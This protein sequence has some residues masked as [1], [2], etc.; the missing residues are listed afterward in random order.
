MLCPRCGHENPDGARFCG[1]C[2]ARLT[3]AGAVPLGEERKIVSVLFCDLVGF[4]E[5]SELF[6][7][8]GDR[9]GLAEVDELDRRVVRN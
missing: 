1:Q 5:A 4:T 6:A 7:A 9:V 3:V 8:M 2:A